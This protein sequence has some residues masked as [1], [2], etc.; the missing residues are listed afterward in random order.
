[1]LSEEQTKGLFVIL[2]I[3]LV[4]IVL[5]IIVINWEDIEKDYKIRNANPETLYN[6]V[7]GHNDDLV[8]DTAIRR[9]ERR[10]EER[11]ENPRD[12]F[13]LAD[14][15]DHNRYRPEV[16]ADH[17]AQL[18]VDIFNFPVE[19]EHF[20]D[21]I[22][23]FVE[24]FP[25]FIQIPEINF[26]PNQARERVV[27][28][29][30]NNAKEK[31]KE[32]L[33]KKKNK[34]K[35]KKKTIDKNKDIPD[36]PDPAEFLFKNEEPTRNEIAE[37][38]FN[39]IQEHNNDPQNVHDVELN[40]QIK[41]EYK[42]IL[43]DNNYYNEHPAE[44]QDLRDITDFA[45][46][47]LK[48]K[49]KDLFKVEKVLNK[50]KDNHYFSGLDTGELNINLEVWN[51]LNL[52]EQERKEQLKESYIDGIVSCVE[53][54]AMGDGIVCMNGR[55]SRVIGSMAVL[56]KDNLGNFKT[57]EIIRNEAFSKAGVITKNFMDDENNKEVVELYNKSGLEELLPED[58]N[59]VD[60]F[61]NKI[62]N[63]IDKSLRNEY[64]FMKP[65]RLEILINEAKAGI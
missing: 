60:E 10:I 48:Q 8:V 41:K 31:A 9:T 19:E 7:I 56:D 5:C 14:L 23:N 39:E 32:K 55:V 18:Y 16:A 34:K 63:E 51:R 49:P 50:V 37:Q 44:K 25:D 46:S 30:V 6:N 54:N 47:Y 12:R 52:P 57:E 15:Y 33:Q 64:K 58:Q 2:I 38:F 28:N 27:Q 42:K 3:L 1:M 21:R 29:K 59:K 20:I 53:K 61:E 40:N 13:I 62:K 22:E 65:E 24:R 4:L 35:N 45:S 26:N 36:I 11:G 17:Y 43:E